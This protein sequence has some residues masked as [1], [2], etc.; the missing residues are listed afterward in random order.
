MPTESVQLW[1]SHGKVIL[2][3]FYYTSSGETVS[4]KRVVY[5]TKI[6]KSNKKGDVLKGRYKEGD[7]KVVKSFYL[8]KID[9]PIVVQGE[10]I[11]PE[12]FVSWVIK[13]TRPEDD[14][15]PTPSA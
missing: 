8:S 5:M 6:E 10:S 4:R 15:S 11:K 13:N 9:S 14:A 3:S 2:V 1:N 12:D 7:T